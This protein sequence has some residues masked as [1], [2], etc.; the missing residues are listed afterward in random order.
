MV[1]CVARRDGIWS[2]KPVFAGRFLDPRPNI[3]IRSGTKIVG[4]VTTRKKIEKFFR[5]AFVITRQIILIREFNKTLMKTHFY[6]IVIY[7]AIDQLLLRA[8]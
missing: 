1:A 7:S 8:R 3:A 5:L 6:L 4:G 2:T